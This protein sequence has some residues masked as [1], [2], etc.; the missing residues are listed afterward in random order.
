[1]PQQPYA[2]PH[3]R[4]DTANHPAGTTYDILVPSHAARARGVE[5]PEALK[6]LRTMRQETPDCILVAHLSNHDR[7]VGCTGDWESIDGSVHPHE[8][9]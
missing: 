8:G 6:S 5:L 1:M 3:S 2:L 9:G 4:R 7:V